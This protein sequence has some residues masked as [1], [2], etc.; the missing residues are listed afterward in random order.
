MCIRD[1]STIDMDTYV[2]S[3][4]KAIC[5]LKSD[6]VLFRITGDPVKSLLVEPKWCQDKLKVIATINKTLKNLGV[7]LLKLEEK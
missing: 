4:V 2:R 5:R 3:V 1:R 6:I 7:P